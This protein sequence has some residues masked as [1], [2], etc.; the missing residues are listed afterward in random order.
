MAQ[1]FFRLLDMLS[2][3]QSHEAVHFP[4]IYNSVLVD[5]NIV[6]FIQ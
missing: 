5:F 3:Q 4:V 2:V 1:H 6:L